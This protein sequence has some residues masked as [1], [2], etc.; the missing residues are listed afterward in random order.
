MTTMVDA[1]LAYAA[2]GWH[3]FPCLEG[4]K[5]PATRRGLLQATT[6]PARIAAWWS[7]RPRLNVAIAC[8][9]SALVVLDCD[10][11]AAKGGAGHGLDH[12][13]DLAR[14]H[15]SHHDL[16]T[17]TV[18][19]PNG[20]V[21]LFYAAGAAPIRSSA[22]RLAPGVDI[23]A[24]GGYALAPPSR[25]AAPGVRDGYV[26]LDG[27]DPAPL[28]PWLERLLVADQRASAPAELT[29]W[30]RLERQVDAPPVTAPDA[31]AR[32]VLERVCDDVRAAANG[33]RNTV[34]HRA[35]LRAGSQVR[36]R[37]LDVAD[38]AAAL[39]AAAAAAGLPADEARGTIRSGLA[40]AIGGG[41]G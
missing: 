19:T 40:W 39:L 31:Y 9:P 13:E 1:A 7:A 8:G 12:V 14:A 26:L 37:G 28:P 22:G 11:L 20:G 15:G 24:A 18:G 10:D 2:R 29:P 35:A 21:H 25:L 17:R 41:G 23:R 6:D 4:A 5:R 27:R 32:A 16:D 38:A 30:E 3:V 34:L 33:Q 36:D